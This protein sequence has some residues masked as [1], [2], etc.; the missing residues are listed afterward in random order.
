MNE[1][2][3]EMVIAALLAILEETAPEVRDLITP[4]QRL[5]ASAS[6]VPGGV[7]VPVPGGG[8]AGLG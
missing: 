4:P 6:A 1:T 2:C 8:P 3:W 7:P 5:T